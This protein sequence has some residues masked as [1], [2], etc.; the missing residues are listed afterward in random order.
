MFKVNNKNTRMT[1]FSS[2]SVFDFEQ[3][4]DFDIIFQTGAQ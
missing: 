2:V 4:Q 1:S 3:D